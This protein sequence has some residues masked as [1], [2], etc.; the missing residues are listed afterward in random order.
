MDSN[1]LNLQLSGHCST[2]MSEYN[3]DLIDKIILGIEEL[4]DHKFSMNESDFSDAHLVILGIDR[5][6]SL[7]R[8]IYKI[9]YYD[10]FTEEIK[11]KIRSFGSRSFWYIKNHMT[12]EERM[13]I[14]L[15]KIYFDIA[16]LFVLRT[17]I[18]GEFF[19]DLRETDIFLLWQDNNLFELSEKNMIII[20]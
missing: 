15:P 5:F 2:N 17:G 16:Y 6:V 9:K 7:C 1:K 4:L 14:S 11:D 19:Y 13:N 3:L 18:L 8:D 20:D 12:Y 10:E